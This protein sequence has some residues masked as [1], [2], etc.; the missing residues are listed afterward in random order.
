MCAII[1]RA[2]M[3]E[4]STNIQ[5]WFLR[6]G[7]TAFD[8]DNSSYDDFIEMLCNGHEIPLLNEHGINFSLLPDRVEFVAYSPARRAVETA[9]LL[10]QRLGAIPME[11]SELLR[12]VRFDRDIILRQEYESLE[13]NR[14]DIL[15]RWY[16][17]RNK[18]EKFEVSL[19]R[20]RAIE[21]F[22]RER[23]EKTMILVTHGW[24][25][26]ILDLYFVQ[27][28]QTITIDDLLTV[29]RV[30]LGNCIEASIVRKSRA[31]SQADPVGDDTPNSPQKTYTGR[32]EYYRTPATPLPNRQ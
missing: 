23:P 20:V 22:I 28:K 3:I 2:N 29:K 18:E 19:R 9:N 7:R 14:K 6:H 11:E 26:R 10:H 31:E 13:R 21:S 1:E 25:L 17:G 15:E 24:F 4:T 16:Y 32:A 27:G 30:E 8:Y 12:E 5:V